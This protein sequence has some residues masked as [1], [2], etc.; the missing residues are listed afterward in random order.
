MAKA[1]D[2]LSQSKYAGRMPAI[3]LF[4][5]GAGGSP[6]RAV[7]ALQ[8]M[9]KQNLGVQVDVQQ[10][11]WA[12]YLND[13]KRRKFQLFGVTSGWIADYADPQD[14]LDI[15]FHSKSYENHMG[16][17]SPALD[18]LL[19]QARVEQDNAK[20]MKIYQDAEQLIVTDAPVIPLHNT[21][22]YWLVKPYV[23]GV[24]RAPMIVP[25]LKNV[26]I[27]EKTN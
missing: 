23:K 26:Y 25:W 15:L 27:Q 21:R 19:E 16:Y 7:S 24:S 12:T 14:F 17:N 9:W 8:E 6:A 11:E 18:K 2:L 22:E 5:S 4:V 3:T 13:L 10:V 1:K 20:R